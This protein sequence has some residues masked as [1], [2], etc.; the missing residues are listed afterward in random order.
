[1]INNTK[2]HNLTLQTV[3][4]V[5]GATLPK[6]IDPKRHCRRVLTQ[7][8]YATPDDVVISAGWYT[9]SQIITESLE[10]NVSLI[11]CDPETKKNYPQNN[12]VPVDD[13]L[14]CVTRFEKWMAEPCHARRIA[15]TGSVGKTTT[16]GL[17]NS[18]IA[19][20]YQTLTHHTMSNSHGAILRNVQQLKP[21]HEYWVQEVGGVQPGYVE[22]SARFLAPDVVVLTNIGES[23]LNLYHTKENIFHDKASLERYAQPDGTVIIN[24]DDDILRSASYTHRVITCSKSNSQADYYAKD[25][26][27]E[28]D[29]THFTAVTKD[30]TIQVHLNIYGEHN[31]YNA[32]F[33]IAVGRLENVPLEK[34]PAFLESYRPSGMRQN[35]VEIGGYHFF[36]DSF[37][38]EPLTILGAAETLEQI[39]ARGNGR[40]IFVTGHIDKLGDGSP[41]MHEKLGHDLS[42]LHLD[43]VVLFAGDSSYTYKAMLEDGCTHVFHTDDREVLDNWLRENITREDI[44]FFRSGQFKAALAKT[45]DHV[46]GTSFQNEQQFN[47][48][49]IVSQGFYQF[50]LRQDNIAELIGYSG[51][52]SELV[53]PESVQGHTVTRI[54]PFA[55]SRQRHITSVIIP[56]SVVSIGQESFYICPALK[57]LKLPAQLKIIGK[58]AFNYCKSLETVDIPYGTIHIDRHAFYDCSALQSITLP[59]TVGFLGEEVFGSDHA[60]KK[61]FTIICEKN[62][63][64]ERFARVNGMSV[65]LHEAPVSATAESVT[66]T[67]VKKRNYSAAEKRLIERGKYWQASYHRRTGDVNPLSEQQKKQ[68]NDF[69]GGYQDLFDIDTIFHSFYLSKCGKFDVR[70]MPVDMYYSFIDPY[71]NNWRIAPV[72]DNKCLY[73]QLFKDTEQP[74]AVFFRMNNIWTDANK[75][76]VD[77]SEI[78]RS[79]HTY[80]ELVMKQ[81]NDSEGGHGVFFIHGEN[82]EEQFISASETIKKDIVVQDSIKQHSVV[83][84]VNPTSI[85][86]IRVLSLLSQTG[87]KIC[88]V[89][90]R[91]GVNGSRVDNISQGGICCGIDQSGRLKNPAYNYKGEVFYSH[92]TSGVHFSDIVIPNY[93]KVLRLVADTHPCIPDFRLVSW[94]IAIDDEGTPLLVEAN[95]CYGELNLHQ[96]CNGPVFGDDTQTILNEVFH[97]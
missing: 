63:Y 80:P 75:R 33:A 49:R 82:M 3:A 22:S 83:K 30:G 66:P 40:R 71:F 2:Q 21:S 67:D 4:E 85:N 46:F 87:V 23:H 38:A 58:N 92:P 54:A 62:S 76:L 11:F 8:V 50:R 88:S 65:T 5:I 68:I 27:V 18:I 69:W 70:Y 60:N 25:I 36:V 97:R 57:T 10:K 17:I 14:A 56:D 59:G 13:P 42:K 16:T 37:N 41:Q 1:M 94:D 24:Y 52:D 34:I 51:N 6:G 95:L 73:Y 9:H 32:L 79:I 93:E 72:I 31:V 26:R 53:I 61:N 43:Q 19:N 91:M 86:T 12:V 35:Y 55:F 20:S 39:P 29:G 7:S 78:M 64:A 84:S 44:I 77:F 81:A 48:G 15:I 28:L 74:K 89:I 45:V 96:L 47:E 90:L